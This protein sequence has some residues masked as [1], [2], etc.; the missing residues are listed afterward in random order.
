[1][2]KI[3]PV[4]SIRLIKILESEGF[5]VIRQKGSYVVLLNDEKIRI[6]V[7]MHPGKE[8]KSGLLR[9]ILNEAGISREKFL[10]IL[11]GNNKK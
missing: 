11:K 6:V 2:P 8:I 10:K 5:K 9:A 7:P 1:M 3:P 4:D